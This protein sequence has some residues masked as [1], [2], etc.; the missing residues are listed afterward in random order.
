MKLDAYVKLN[1]F[2]DTYFKKSGQTGRQWANNSEEYIS[3]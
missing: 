1:E 3:H 2:S